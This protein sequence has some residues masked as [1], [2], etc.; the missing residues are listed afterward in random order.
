MQQ[1]VLPSLWPRKKNTRGPMGGEGLGEG[2]DGTGGGAVGGD[3]WEGEDVTMIGKKPADETEG[4]RNKEGENE[5]ANAKLRWRGARGEVIG[6][7][8]A[9]AEAGG[10]YQ[11]PGGMPGMNM[12]T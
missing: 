10:E 1:V 7:A 4:Q 5:N 6:S 11:M 2:G 12:S 8:R 3:E 9:G